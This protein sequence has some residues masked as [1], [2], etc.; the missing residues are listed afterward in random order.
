MSKVQFIRRY[1]SDRVHRLA[2]D[3]V[4]TL[5]DRDASKGQR[6]RTPPKLQLCD[7]CR[8]QHETYRRKR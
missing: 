4:T 8:V 1:I 5:C 3:G 7:A 6:M 2:D